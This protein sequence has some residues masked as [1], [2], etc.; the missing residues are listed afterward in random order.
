MISFSWGAQII[1]S[2]IA[3]FPAVSPPA[4]GRE[5][6]A[7]LWTW[8]GCGSQTKSLISSTSQPDPMEK[9][10]SAEESVSEHQHW[11]FQGCDCSSS[12]PGKG[13]SSV[14]AENYSYLNT[15][16]LQV[17]IVRQGSPLRFVGLRGR[18][19]C[20]WISVFCTHFTT[21]PSSQFPHQTAEETQTSAS[22]S[23]I[24]IS[25]YMLLTKCSV[26]N[27]KLARILKRRLSGYL[28]L[29]FD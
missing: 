9:L 13:L 11:S 8:E 14:S 29:V 19:L 12:H 3:C 26:R 21:P 1:P 25:Q 28:E 16:Q 2:P 5:R 6:V 7:L 15:S 24:K 17:K 10:I 20:L 27:C 23:F 22:G 18:A 4:P